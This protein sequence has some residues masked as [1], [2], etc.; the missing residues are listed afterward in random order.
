MDSGFD[1][2]CCLSASCANLKLVNS[3]PKLLHVEVV[4]A[5][6]SHILQIGCTECY[7][8]LTVTANCIMPVCVPW[9]YYRGQKECHF[10]QFASCNKCI[11]VMYKIK[12]KE[13]QKYSNWLVKA[14]SYDVNSCSEALPVCK[15]CAV[16][17][18]DPYLN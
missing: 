6:L 18:M 15:C 12:Y 16:I 17:F 4:H 5:V 10:V 7:Y 1:P 9:E 3:G 8:V 13:I 14:E 2:K 11:G